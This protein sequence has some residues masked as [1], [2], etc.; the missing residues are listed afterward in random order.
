MRTLRGERGL[1][2]ALLVVVIAW[3]LAAV[4]M[5]TGT[6]LSAQRIEQTMPTIVGSTSQID[7]DLDSIRLAARTSRISAD[8]LTT[9][10]PLAGQ[11]DQVI[12]SARGIDRTA[13]SILDRARAI[14]GSVITI[15]TTASSINTQVRS[16]NTTAGAINANVSSILTTARGIE[17]TAG[18]INRNARSING[19]VRSIN[20]R[21]NSINASVNSID[22]RLAG[23]L[24]ET[25]T[26]DPGVAGI[27]IRATGRGDQPRVGRATRSVASNL[28]PIR[29]DF[30]DILDQLGRP[31]EAA[32]HRAPDGG[33]TIHGHA[34][35]IDC[36]LNPLPG[37][38]RGGNQCNR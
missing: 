3:A 12:V 16:I 28:N 27:N 20:G 1:A 26:I 25:R 30:A 35:S 6:I 18:A 11:L 9:A 21:V 13:R 23:T 4:L 14:N 19:R 7:G 38:P 10:R 29:D 24:A 34:N 22:G 33:K 32:G 8:I 36:Q 31:P 37:P 15:N 17:S 2:P 5:L